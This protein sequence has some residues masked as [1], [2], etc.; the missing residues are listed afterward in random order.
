MPLPA[1]P[2][3]CPSSNRC[4]TAAVDTTAIP[5]VLATALTTLRARGT[6]AVVGLGAPMADLPVGLIMG[7]G[8]TV[9][10]VV[11]GD[12]D[13]HT[14]IPVLVNLWARGDLPLDLL[15]TAY[16]FDDFPVA[17]ADA[18]AGRVVKPVLC[19]PR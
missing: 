7:R 14:F 18:K 16:S 6:L 5:E 2:I 15:V 4:V 13:R 12:S 1:K 10:G 8:L 19:T 11:E 17:W 3:R 9:R